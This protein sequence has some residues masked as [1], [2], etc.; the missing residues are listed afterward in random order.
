[1]TQAQDCASIIQCYRVAVNPTKGV[2][3]LDTLQTLDQFLAQV[4]GRAY[5][6]AQIA[7][8]NSDDALDLVQDAMFKLVEKYADH[9]SA[10]W[11]PLF[12]KILQSRINDWHRRSS[13]R[14]RFR[15]WFGLAED[16]QE[17]PI[18]LAP[19]NAQRSPEEHVQLDFSM[20]ALQKALQALPR[21]Q[22]QVFLLRVWEGLDV[23]QTALAMS[24]AQGS[25]KTH[26][27]RAVHT[28]RKTLGEHYP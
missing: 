27:S 13:V 2:Q 18:Q 14:N 26:Y 15:S 23:R 17:D 6:I 10:E 11:G 25:V 3:A 21:R 19:D 28:L 5:K 24:C 1:M 9:D 8:N 16:D 22:Q 20:D 7:T 4:Q 12:Y